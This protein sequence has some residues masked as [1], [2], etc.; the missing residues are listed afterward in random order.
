MI[1]VFQY[2]R[3]DAESIVAGLTIIIALARETRE[4]RKTKRERREPQGWLVSSGG[5]ENSVGPYLEN[6]MLSLF[7]S[8]SL[9]PSFRPSKQR[10]YD[11]VPPS[12]NHLTP[13]RRWSFY[14]ESRSEIRKCEERRNSDINWSKCRVDATFILENSS[15]YLRIN[16][17]TIEYNI[18]SSYLYLI[19]CE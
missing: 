11:K 10:G 18:F 13:R 9:L 4:T 7:L 1:A 15:L 2:L 6:E 12:S 17:L 16:G 5:C 19:L 3:G 8:L 14:Y